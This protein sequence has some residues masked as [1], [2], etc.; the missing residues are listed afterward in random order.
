MHRL[1]GST[2]FKVLF[3]ASTAQR[4]RNQ[5][6][7]LK[8]VRYKIPCSIVDYGIAPSPRSA[9]DRIACTAKAGAT[10]LKQRRPQYCIGT[11]GNI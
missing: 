9:R 10:R 7:F 8:R 6:L 2:T 1:N 5:D 4:R 11:P 3:L